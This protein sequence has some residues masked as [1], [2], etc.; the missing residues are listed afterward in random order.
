[1]TIQYIPFKNL[2]PSPKNVRKRKTGIDSLAASIASK[3]GLIQNLVVLARDNGKYEV[4]AGERRRRAIAKLV[5]DGIWTK[6]AAIPC[7]V[8]ED[9]NA[10]SMSYAENAQREDMHPAESIQVFGQLQ[11]EGHNEEAIAN[12]FGYELSEVRKLLALANV[13]PKVLKALAADKIDVA[14]VQAFT[15]TDDHE[16]QERVL[17]LAS[18]AHQVRRLLTETKLTTDHKL[19]RFVGMDAYRD[20]GG[21]I[22]GDL[23]AGEGEGYADDPELVERLADEKL[24]HLADEARAEGWREVIAV[25]ERP[26]NSYSWHTLYPDKS[27]RSF[28]D[29][30]QAQMDE[31]TAKREA[32]LA[33]IGADNDP[34]F[35]PESDDILIEIDDEIDGIGT[36]E[37][38]FSAQAKASGRI[39]I[40]LGYQGKIDVS[41]YSLKAQHSGKA[42][43]KGASLP[44]PLYDA[45][46][47]EEL[48]R[49]RTAA[50][51][52]EV[53]NNQPLAFAVLL[54]ALLPV[55]TERYPAAHAVELRAGADMQEPCKHFDYNSRE[56]ASPFDC[57]ADL[58]GAAPKK[59]ANRFAWIMSLAEHDVLRMLA[60]CSGAL[61]NATQGKYADPARLKSADRIAR[62]ANLDMR[63]HW[64]GGIE[65]FDRIGKKALLSA[66]TEAC[67]AETAENCEKMKKSALAEACAERIPGRGWLPSLLISPAEPAAEPEDEID[68]DHEDGEGQGH[69]EDEGENS[70]EESEF[71]DD[72]MNDDQEIAIAAE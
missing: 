16:R 29:A 39:M 55:L 17:K 13:S 38:H 47:T 45:R 67:G 34:D 70:D 71:H 6:D 4:I 36:V 9:E 66:L 44:R 21:T 61:I 28:T 37:R 46:M 32:R 41:H 62:A 2:V 53:A 69:G 63:Q 8:G 26:H 51:Q 72:A 5:K 3:D 7:K 19:F 31:L 14:C 58:I 52:A 42:G 57:V 11:S 40:L 10:T 15:L 20:A 18:S 25:M 59:P 24:D 35:A 56:M 22:T 60:A 1:M 30:E 43:E 33:E 23:F 12:R 68:A 48:S 49:M 27:T 54:D 50:L 65:F 64:E